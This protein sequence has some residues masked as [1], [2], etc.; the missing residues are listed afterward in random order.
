MH[1]SNR[2]GARFGQLGEYPTHWLICAQISYA[3]HER[4]AR[5]RGATVASIGSAEENEA[6]V[7]VARGQFCFVGAIRQG[8]G[9]G[10]CGNQPVRRVRPIILH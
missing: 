5:E 4:K 7:R 3:E 9:N 2:R 6:V 10:L 1:E 8:G